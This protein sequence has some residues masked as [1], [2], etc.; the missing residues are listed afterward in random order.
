MCGGLYL[1]D[2]GSETTLILREGRD[3]LVSKLSPSAIH[4]IPGRMPPRPRAMPT[5]R[6]RF[7]GD[8]KQASRLSSWKARTWRANF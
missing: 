4:L 5:T 2:G 3:F 7:D 1:T 6:L 8:S